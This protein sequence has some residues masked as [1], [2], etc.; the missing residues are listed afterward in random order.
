MRNLATAR[1]LKSIGN[2]EAD[3]TEAVSEHFSYVRELAGA[4]GP[5]EVKIEGLRDKI[6]QGTFQ[7]DS[8][9]VA[10]RMLED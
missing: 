10:D 3:S 7:I 8:S 1:A 2:T 5:A 9:L 6:E 4:K